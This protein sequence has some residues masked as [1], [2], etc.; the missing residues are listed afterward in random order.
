MEKSEQGSH[1]PTYLQVSFWLLNVEESGETRQEAS[2]IAQGKMMATWTQSQRRRW[3]EGVAVWVYS[4]G[5]TGFAGKLANGHERRVK[6][7]PAV[8]GLRNWKNEVARN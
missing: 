1:D 2:A 3:Q 7:I 4:K 5:R 8:L 6:N